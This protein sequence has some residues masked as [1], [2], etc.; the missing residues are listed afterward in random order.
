[1]KLT[2][3]EVQ[4]IQAKIQP[5]PSKLLRCWK[6]LEELLKTV[7]KAHNYSQDTQEV[8]SDQKDWAQ[9]DGAHCPRL[10]V[11]FDEQSVTY[12]AGC[13][14]EYTYQFQ[15]YGLTRDLDRDQFAIYMA[16]VETAINDNNSLFGQANKM[17]VPYVLADQQFFP[18]IDGARMFMMTVKVESTREARIAT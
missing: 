2:V 13:V 5:L 1:M 11:S 9:V 6:G 12:H 10:E 17:E 16:E 18:R 7:D 4:A 3:P 14:R 15:I 8:D